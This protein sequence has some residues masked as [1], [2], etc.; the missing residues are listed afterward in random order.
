MQFEMKYK[1]SFISSFNSNVLNEVAVS[2]SVG[3][4]SKLSLGSKWGRHNS[5]GVVVHVNERSG[6]EQ[7]SPQGLC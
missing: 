4:E 1:W 3:R 7:L 2:N 5:G 6:K